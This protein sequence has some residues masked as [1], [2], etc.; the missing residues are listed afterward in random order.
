[1]ANLSTT[2]M[3]LN[4]KN[5]IIASS[6]GLTGIIKD[7]VD[8]EVKGVG[9]LVLKS[10]F[11][12]EI[13]SETQDNLNK[14]HSSGFIYPE[15]MEYFDFDEMED[16]VAN[17]LKLISEAKAKVKI[18]VIASINCVTADKWPDFAKRIE[19]AGADG[20]ELNV[21]A[22]PTDMN[23]S[24]ADNDKLY[25]DIIE[26]VTT[27]TNLPVAVKI[28][29]YN[30]SLASFIKRLSDT[31][32]KGIV[33]FNRF[34][35]PDFD[36]H[37]FEFTSSNV[38]STPSEIALS[39]RW[40]AIMSGRVDTDFAASTG[41]HNGS[42]AIKQILAGAKAVQIC[43]TLYRNGFDQVGQITNELNEWMDEKGFKSIEDFRGKMSQVKTYNPAA[44]E[45]VQF[46]KYFRE[47]E[48]S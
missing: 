46:M 2:Y 4:L 30:S 37:N 32:I 16:P 12:E 34:Y 40:I 33:L 38:F 6:S 17:F 10:I 5:P 44:F 3:G 8:L 36:I 27:V 48:R 41:V 9:A 21:F 20:L 7:I 18:P 25:F 22:L 1:M 31:K 45:R 19:A 26:R 28:S 47:L 42:G 43:S 15:T 24:A 39:L 23:R 29:P 11:E 13:I 14:M 35:S